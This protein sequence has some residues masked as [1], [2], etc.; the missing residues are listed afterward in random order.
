[1]QKIYA[2]IGIYVVLTLIDW[3]LAKFNIRISGKLYPVICGIVAYVL[4]GFVT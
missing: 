1:M 3:L 2:A 4:F